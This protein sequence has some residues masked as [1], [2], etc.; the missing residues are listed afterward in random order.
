MTERERE[1]WATGYRWYEQFASALRQAALLDDNGEMAWNLFGALQNKAN[2]FYVASSDADS[3]L[4]IDALY[5]I[6][7]KVYKEARKRAGKAA[8]G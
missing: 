1:A 2:D 8:D 6:L 7:E 5:G 3:R 4:L